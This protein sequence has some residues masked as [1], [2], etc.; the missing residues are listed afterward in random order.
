MIII[1]RLYNSNK[2]DKRKSKKATI[3]KY[4]DELD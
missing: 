4:V 1:Q 3:F 2:L